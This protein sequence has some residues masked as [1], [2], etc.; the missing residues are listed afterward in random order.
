MH[1]VYI[2]PSTANGLVWR[3]SP[4]TAAGPRWILTTFPIR[5]NDADTGNR[6]LFTFQCGDGPPQTMRLS[7]PDPNVK[8]KIR[9][10]FHCPLVRRGFVLL[11]PLVRFVPLFQIGFDLPLQRVP[12]LDG[13]V[14]LS[15][16]RSL[17]IPHDA[18]IRHL[19]N[20]SR[21]P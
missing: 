12:L 11:R 3:S 18:R 10:G 15:G 16:L 8:E 20:Q 7:E 19:L 1:A 2:P 4:I 21:S 9:R 13:H 6:N 17:E 5:P 14:D